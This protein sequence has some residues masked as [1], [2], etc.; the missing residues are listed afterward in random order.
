MSRDYWETRYQEKDTPWVKGEPLPG[1][2]DFLSGPQAPPASAV[3]VPGCGMGHDVHAWADAGHQV[4][5][6][7]I[8]EPATM[9][10]RAQVPSGLKGTASFERAD[11]L[12]DAPPRGQRFDW[13][14]EHTLFCAIDRN[15]RVD[16]VMAMRR[17]LKPGGML[18]AT[19]YLLPEEEEGPPFGLA[20]GEIERR[21]SPYFDAV[22][23]WT[24]RSWPHRQGLERMY[25]WRLRRPV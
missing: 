9:L 22:Q 15:R 10:A 21:F 23:E 18:L 25:L 12:A 2:L 17:W 6:V 19:H 24:P 1:L 3:C 11:F 4:L 14:F 7:D 8:A 20:A 13:I 5:G 16:Y